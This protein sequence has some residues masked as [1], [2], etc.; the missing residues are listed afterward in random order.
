MEILFTNFYPLERLTPIIVEGA[1]NRNWNKHYSSNGA[2]SSR[3][4]PDDLGSGQALLAPKLLPQEVLPPEIQ[5]I[6][7]RK[8]SQT[9]VLL[10]LQVS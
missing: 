10:M 3:V 5:E 6:N 9:C 1:L 8:C 4:Y 2:S 7:Q